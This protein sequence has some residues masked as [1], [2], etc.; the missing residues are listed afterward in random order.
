MQLDGLWT[1]HTLLAL[2]GFVLG[3]PVIN[4][5]LAAPRVFIS[6]KGMGNSS[7][8]T[9]SRLFGIPGMA[10]LLTFSICRKRDML[11]SVRGVASSV[12]VSPVE[13]PPES[14]YGL[15]QCFAASETEII[16]QKD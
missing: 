15:C 4:D 7:K 3:D 14:G 10:A 6:F 9:G 13:Q 11:C 5:P 1:V 16:S 2:S 8:S 12:R